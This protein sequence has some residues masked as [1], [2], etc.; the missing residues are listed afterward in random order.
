MKIGSAKFD[1]ASRLAGRPQPSKA[2]NGSTGAV[3]PKLQKPAGDVSSYSLPAKLEPYRPVFDK[4]GKKI[5]RLPTPELQQKAIDRATNRLS[6]R[7]GGVATQE[8]IGK[9]VN[10]AVMF[11]SR[12]TTT[13]DPQAYMMARG[14]VDGG[15]N[16]KQPGGLAERLNRDTFEILPYQ[17]RRLS[18]S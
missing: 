11:F 4:V 9:A 12:A 16:T 15:R 6:K 13:N 17:P 14:P 18:L 1:S 2:V 7:L 5:A 3:A 8:E 10:E